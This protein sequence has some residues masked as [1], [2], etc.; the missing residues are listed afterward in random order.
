MRFIVI[1]FSSV[2]CNKTTHWPDVYEVFTFIVAHWNLFSISHVD[3]ES[4]SLKNLKR[5]S[6]FFETGKKNRS[7]NKNICADRLKAGCLLVNITW[8]SS[9]GWLLC[10]LVS[11]SLRL[12]VSLTSQHRV[13]IANGLSWMIFFH[14]TVL[15]LLLWS[16]SLILVLCPFPP[17]GGSGSHVSALVFLCGKQGWVCCDVLTFECY[18]LVLWHAGFLCIN[19]NTIQPTPRF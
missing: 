9:G 2:W 12:H 4:I 8:A 5:R 10:A 13:S 19:L 14:G 11:M 16:R 17:S 3:S 18:S 7:I 15:D 6:E 1:T